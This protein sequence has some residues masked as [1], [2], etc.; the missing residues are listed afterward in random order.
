PGFSG[1]DQELSG[2]HQIEKAV[3]RDA[4][5]NPQLAGGLNFGFAGDPSDGLIGG[6]TTT[7][8]VRLYTPPQAKW[9]RHHAAILFGIPRSRG[10]NYIVNEV[11]GI[12]P[13]Y[14]KR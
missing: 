9:Y 7:G 14:P 2:G 10:E 4:T 3:G 12:R 1:D 5:E 11:T 13:D 8:H 6:S